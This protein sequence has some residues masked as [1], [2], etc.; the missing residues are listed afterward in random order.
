M[1]KPFRQRYLLA[2]ANAGDYGG[3]L[4]TSGNNIA[5]DMQ[6]ADIN[7]ISKIGKR[8]RTRNHAK[9]QQC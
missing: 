9:R 3:R 8:Q 1:N 5:D 2:A 7:W 6:D 4:F